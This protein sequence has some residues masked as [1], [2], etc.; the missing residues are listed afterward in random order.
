MTARMDPE[1]SPLQ[2]ILPDLSPLEDK[3]VR[4]QL[5]VQSTMC[6][7][8]FLQTRYRFVDAVAH[9]SDFVGEPVTATSSAKKALFK[10]KN[11]LCQVSLRRTMTALHALGVS[12]QSMAQNLKIF[13]EPYHM[14]REF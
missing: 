7:P 5:Q 3:L 9:L 10:R 14:V 6:S 4:E 8:K 13:L 1:S 2:I 11:F 12:K